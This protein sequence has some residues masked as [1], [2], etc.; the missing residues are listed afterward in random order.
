LRQVP[1][2]A[3]AA[4]VDLGKHPRGALLWRHRGTIDEPTTLI[5]ITITLITL[6][7]TLIPLRKAFGCSSSSTSA[8]RALGDTLDELLD[9]EASGAAGTEI[10]TRDSSIRLLALTGAFVAD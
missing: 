7:T 5:T 9:P 3:Q 4:G 1:V 2:R 10:S 8:P 6:T